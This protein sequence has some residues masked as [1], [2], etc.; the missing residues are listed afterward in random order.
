MKHKKVSLR[1]WIYNTY[2]NTCGCKNCKNPF[3]LK[4]NAKNVD[5]TSPKSLPGIRKACYKNQGNYARLTS[6]KFFESTGDQV[7]GSRW[8]MKEELTLSEI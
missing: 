7:R 8:D 4:I 6:I 5:P 2:S 3:G 1:A